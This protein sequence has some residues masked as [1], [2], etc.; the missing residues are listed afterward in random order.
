M[1]NFKYII[2]SFMIGLLFMLKMP[3][4]GAV[5]YGGSASD[6][7]YGTGYNYGIS[8]TIPIRS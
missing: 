8:G 5:A 4:A 2:F 3:L 7:C 6:A 1:K